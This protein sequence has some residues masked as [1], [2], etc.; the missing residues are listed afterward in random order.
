MPFKYWNAGGACCLDFRIVIMGGSSPHNAV[1][2]SNVLRPVTNIDRDPGVDQVLSR[3]G[4]IHIGAGNGDSHP[5]QDQTK[6]THGHA[7][8]ADKMD[9]FPGKQALLQLL[10]CRIHVKKTS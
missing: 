4:C 8:D 2:P 7:A 3:N 9:V 10:D 1:G 6:G 5:L